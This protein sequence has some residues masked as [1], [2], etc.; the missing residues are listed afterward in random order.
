MGRIG[1]MGRAMGGSIFDRASATG[2]RLLMLMLLVMVSPLLAEDSHGDPHYAVFLAD[3]GVVGIKFDLRLG[4][5]TP[6]ELFDGYIDQLV[7]ELDADHDG[8]VTVEE[9]RGKFLTVRDAQQLQLVPAVVP[10]GAA[11]TETSPDVSPADGKITRQEF[12][13]YYKRLGLSPFQVI[14]Q[15]NVSRQARPRQG[16]P[17]TNPTEVPLFV[18][19]DA[20]GDSRLSAD[21]LKG[22]LDTLRKLDLDNDEMISAAEL[23]SS[24]VTNQF[25]VAQPAPSNQAAAVSP[26]LSVGSLE[27]ITK[28]VR[29]LIEKYDTTDPVKS[30]VAEAKVRNQK[31]SPLELGIP[32]EAFSR[33]DGDGDRQLDF[34]EL[35][36]FL[37]SPDSTITIAGDLEAAPAL[38]VESSRPD[39][40]EKL[41]TSSDGTVNINLGSIQMTVSRGASFD[42]AGAE[43]LLKPQFM[44]AD[45][46]A[47]GYLEKGEAER[48][49]L[50]G[51][52]FEDLDADRNK[53]VFFD[54]I[55]AYFRI[56][57][58][59]AR[60]RVILTISEQGRTLFEILDTDRDRRLSFREVQAAVEKL[61]LWDK[62]QDGLLAESEIPLQ[63]RLVVARGTLPALS[64]NFPAQNGGMNPSDSVGERSSGPIWFRKMD[65]NGD[66]EVSRREF[67]G[68]MSVFDSLDRNQDGFL[69]LAEALRT[70]DAN[71]NANARE[72]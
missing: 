26:F 63:Y 64:N 17:D 58:N 20:N 59:A 70:G 25:A 51:V 45:A 34:D 39:I 14:Y 49:F 43:L 56:R 36:Q 8:I 30:G 62:D 11:V 1:P 12:I 37:G 27:P 61:P 47:N 3:N 69:D 67:L 54:E 19:L 48:A 15:P 50:F 18:R 29:R 57:F 35:R 2:V 38:K 6:R 4:G 72:K 66:G 23:N 68:E 5:K 9:A 13:A 33:Y 46:D 32:A 60:S 24:V 10:Q 16:R 52:S 7:T 41:K 53:K 42:A 71:Q 22:A 65:K 44:A 21:E 28:Q 40:Q 31:L 55:Q